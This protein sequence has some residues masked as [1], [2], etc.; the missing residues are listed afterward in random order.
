M[1]DALVG[2]EPVLALARSV[3]ADA[4]GGAGQLL[5][6]CGEPGI[7][8]T[9]VLTEL[10]RDARQHGARVLWGACWDGG[11]VPAYW[12]WMQVL[13]GVAG[14]VD[15]VSLGGARQLVC[16][17]PDG[18][19]DAPAADPDKAADAR[20]RLFDSVARLMIL[21]AQ[22]TSVIVV[23]DDLQWADQPSLRLLDFL[24][25]QLTTS[26]VAVLGAYRDTEANESLR[27]LAA[28][29]QLLPLGG[30][31]AADVPA[32]MAAVAG[33]AAPGP[34]DPRLAQHV[35][36]RSGGNPLFVRELTRLLLAQGGWDGGQAAGAP[37]PDTVRDT[38]ERRLA[39]LSQPCVELLTV[40]ALAGPEIRP[41]LLATALPA[42]GPQSD[43]L[44]EALRARVLATGPAGGRRFVHD[45]FRETL[46]AGLPAARRAELHVALGRAL[47]ARRAAGAAV[48]AG[49]LA[50]H[51][52]AAGTTA[53]ASQAVRYSVSAAREATAQLGHEDACRQYEQ[54]LRVLDR[55][56]DAASGDHPDRT[57]LL[58]E[59]AAA[60]D[61]SG[62]TGAARIRFRQAAEL[63]RRNGDP[64]GLAGAA[65]GV[66]GLGAR[67]GS[68]HDEAIDL[69]AEAAA[70][71]P[72]QAA[73]LRARVLASLARALW[74]ATP[75]P[76]TPR[77]R[78]CAEQAVELARC[79]DDPAGL[80]F[81]LLALHD[82]YWM[83]GSGRQRLE[84]LTDMLDAA[85]RAGDRDL[86]A[87]A[88]LLRAAALLELGDPTGLVVLS[89]YVQLADEL[90]HA[91]G[92]WGALTRRA[93]LALL[94][95]RRDEAAVLAGR[96]LEL[97]RMIGQVDAYGVWATLRSSLAFLG[98]PPV[99]MDTDWL[100]ADP[101]RPLV[102]LL[103]A[104]MQISAGHVEEARDELAGFAVDLVPHKHDLEILAVLAAAT[105]VAGSDGQR[106][107]VYR[108]LL[109][110]AGLHVVVGGCA[111]YSGAMDHHLGILAASLGCFDDA[112]GHL[113]AAI[114][115]HERL[116]AD[117]WAQLSRAALAE[118]DVAAPV[119][120][121]RW[122]GA[123]WT[124]RYR[125]DS[126]HLPD[127]K[128]LHDLAALL[129]TPG[130]PVHVFT[131]LGRDLPATGADP[132][133]DEPARQA[134]R[135][136]LAE[137]DA[138]LDEASTWAD[139]GRVERVRGERDALVRELTAAAGLGGRSRRLGDETERARKTVT[140]RIRDTLSRIERAHPALGE[141]LR[142]AVSTGTT[143]AY[144]P[145]EPTPWKLSH[146]A[147]R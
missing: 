25:R 73:A 28:I 61:R 42:V 140:A 19:A 34:P 118:L 13:R 137:L 56:A 43:L 82:T 75:G 89:S 106:H 116:G 125:G 110:H 55:P 115:M 76:P 92:R 123:I 21:L 101:M 130:H 3:L 87:Q 135:A 114:E 108:R 67:S 94:T 126:A 26:R 11:A 102:P 133:L 122:D 14:T 35:W 113:R 98:A 95:G 146:R 50:A 31:V 27:G 45:L 112:A 49:E 132:V 17:D 38:L 128:G 143:C 81:A 141:H 139:L 124:V 68:T 9:A 79:G 4:L 74:H 120:V 90:G 138:E 51:F 46:I 41:E 22:E 127:A 7:G 23:L 111:S 16:P 72:P 54:A 129:A 40:A 48:S 86:L 100:M 105:A 83:P 36:R 69:L 134:Y 47:E 39:R 107:Q 117:A 1:A 80:A 52:A 70:A 84:V 30:L 2:R 64:V 65:I 121:L 109:P 20:F 29:G 32:L 77:A 33:P 99:S 131:L 104:W 91:R 144:T 145:S 24:I 62:A 44:E 57:M 58:L 97:G 10:A 18:P 142:A 119:N 6:L 8:K 88:Q 60:Q 71:L 136:R 15:P 37:I 147:H 93:T 5:L 12:P 96:G 59:L 85:E 53:V 66:H 78:R 63:A 103:A